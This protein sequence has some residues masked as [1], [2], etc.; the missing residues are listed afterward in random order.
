MS[1]STLELFKGERRVVSVEFST[2]DDAP[3]TIR[4]A[5]Y[6]LLYDDETESG[7]EPIIEGHKLTMTL[8]PQKVGRYVLWC[9]IEVANELIIRRLPVFV[10][11]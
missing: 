7:G 3:F 6:K 8:E 9:Q 10:R 2:C 5:S 4:N 11:A 1:C